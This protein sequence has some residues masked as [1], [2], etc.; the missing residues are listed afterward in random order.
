[1]ALMLRFDIKTS[2]GYWTTHVGHQETHSCG[3]LF[4]ILL[5]GSL[6]AIGGAGRYSRIAWS[7][8][9][10][11]KLSP[12]GL[13]YLHSKYGFCSRNFHYSLRTYSYG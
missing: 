11:Y 8:G 7:F 10:A 3:G 4:L 1:M 9:G 2:S 6:A 5:F 12:K 13:R